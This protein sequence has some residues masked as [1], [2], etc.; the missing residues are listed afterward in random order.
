[1]D[2]RNYLKTKESELQED[3][4]ALKDFIDER[5]RE[6]NEKVN[7][8]TVIQ[9]LLSELT[10]NSESTQTGQPKR[11]YRRGGKTQKEIIIEV[12]QDAENNTLHLDEI[13]ERAGQRGVEI[14]RETLQSLLARAKDLFESAPGPGN[15]KLKTIEE[16]EIQKPATEDSGL[17]NGL[18]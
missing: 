5:Q 14:K 18:E 15:W 9:N 8:L 3:I 7:S 2:A 17:G 10:D 6:L 11:L 13:I 4:E 12:L 16:S 1:M